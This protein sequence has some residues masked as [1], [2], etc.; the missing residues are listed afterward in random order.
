MNLENCGYVSDW[1]CAP[2]FRWLFS[3]PAQNLRTV[4]GF[5]VLLLQD[6]LLTEEDE[7]LPL[8]GHVVST[9][10]HFYFVEDFIFLVFMGSEKVVVCNP[11]GK[12]I[13]SAVDVIKAVCVTVRSL[14]SAVEPLNHLLEWAVFCRNR[15][16]VGKPNDL[17]DFEG[18][19][20]PELLYEFHCGERIGA[21]TVSDELKVFGQLGK[22]PECHAHGEDAWADTTIIGYLVA[23]NGTGCSIHDKPD[24]CFE[25]ADFYVGFIGSKDI[26]FFVRI[27]VNKGFDAAGSGLTIVGDLLVGDTDVIQIFECLRGFAQ[28]QP[29]IDM[30]GQAQ[31]HDMCVVLTEFQGRCVLWKGV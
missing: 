24:V 14:I 26:S 16:V 4:S 2:P 27:L 3:L 10:Q 12:V 18:K 1:Q 30:E 8:A 23:D 6:G 22:T 25:T 28:G 31:G 15:I 17:S 7:K 19:V 9:L 13:I 5:A 29:E 21:V 11:E 20:F